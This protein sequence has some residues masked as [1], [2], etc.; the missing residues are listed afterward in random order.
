MTSLK[1]VALSLDIGGSKLV[2]G[3][4]DIEG[5]VLCKE[6]TEWTTLS[7]E[8]LITTILD[9][10]S[11]ILK[12]NKDINATCIG[13]NIPGLA[14]TERGIWV[15]ACF[16]GI[17]N[18]PI[19]DILNSQFGLPVYIDNDVNNCALAEKIFGICQDCTDFIWLTVSNGCGGAIFIDNCI[20]RGVRNTAGELGHITVEE[21]DGILCG[22][23]NT[24]CLEAQAAGPGIIRRYLDAGGQSELNGVKVSAKDIADIAMS[25]DAPARYV[26][27]MEG[28]YLGK[29]LAAAINTL[30][31]QKVVIGGGVSE[32]FDLFYPELIKTVDKM[33]YREASKH[34][35]IEK[36]GLGYDAALIGATSLAFTRLKSM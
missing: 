12:G 34:I 29:A 11:R 13:V 26:F 7:R 31:P 19:A 22:C 32:A 27:S 18:I 1:Q 36:T 6:K 23:G 15:E 25:G 9:A 14:D 33:T 17:K 35:V 10:A 4:V 24:G 5:N 20:Y 16:S 21:K 8:S 28:Y 2:T 30:N 3:L